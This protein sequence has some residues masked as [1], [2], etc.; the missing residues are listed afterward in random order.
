MDQKQLFKQMIRFNQTT[1]NN[2]FY[3]MTQLQDQLERMSTT[4]MDQIP[5]ISADARK[6]VEHWA[7]IFKDGRDNV[8]EQ[9]DKSFEQ[10]ERLF[11]S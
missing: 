6:A 4:V 1:Y 7:R 3:A 8:K 2:A 9:A 11:I 10:A 5:G